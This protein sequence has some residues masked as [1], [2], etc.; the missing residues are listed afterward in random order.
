MPEPHLIPSPK[1]AG[2]KCNFFSKAES[3][4]GSSSRPP[5]RYNY[6]RFYS[7]TYTLHY[8]PVPPFRLLSRRC[9]S[10]SCCFPSSTRVIGSLVVSPS[11]V[12][13]RFRAMILFISNR[14]KSTRIGS[15]GGDSPFES[16]LPRK[17]HRN[18]IIIYLSVSTSC[19]IHETQMLIQITRAE[20]HNNVCKYSPGF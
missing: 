12:R 8:P 13:L 1:A 10:L 5:S 17:N 4:E 6:L 14:Q 19:I 11:I 3:N 15:L 2:D 20:I 7:A 16:A 18:P 9:Q